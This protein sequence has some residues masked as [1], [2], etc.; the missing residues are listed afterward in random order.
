MALYREQGVVL[1][2]YKLGEADRIINILTPGRGK[3]RCVAKGVRKTSSRLGG[4]ME[5]YSHVDLQLY[6]GRNLDIVTQAQLITSFSEV[7][8]DFDLS[9]C[10]A[11]VVE[12]ADRI[13]QEGEQSNRAFLLV[14][15]ALRRLGAAPDEPQGVLDAFVLRL[16][17]AAG[18]HPITEA[19]AACGR[20]YDPATATGEPVGFH[21]AAGGVL[22]A[23][24][25]PPQAQRVMPGTIALLHARSSAGDWGIASA[26]AA[27]TRDRRVAAA[28]VRSFFTYHV[29]RPL[30]AWEL[31]PR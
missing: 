20:A 5:P 27:D 3:V 15:E 19:C 2:T 9:T 23:R 6:E 11:G 28:L 13:A 4:R 12:A 25:R 21:I 7:R 14:L 18:Y 30:R 1:R 16:A 10:A 31:V 17:S 22:C 29:G 26:Q 8:A 24:C